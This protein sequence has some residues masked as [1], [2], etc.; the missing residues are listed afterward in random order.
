[1]SVIFENMAENGL[2][3]LGLNTALQCLDQAAQQAAAGKWSYTH[4]LGYLLDS[5]VRAKLQKNVDEINGAS[6]NI[7]LL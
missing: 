5:E 7:S 6:T 2:E 4:F 1:M 3:E